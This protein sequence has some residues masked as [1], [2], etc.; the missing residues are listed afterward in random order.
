MPWPVGY[1]L[2]ALIEP[3]YFHAKRTRDDLLE[4][5]E[6]KVDGFDQRD[7]RVA[8]VR[9]I[10]L[11]L[12]YAAMNCA[13]LQDNVARD[14]WWERHPYMGAATPTSVTAAADNYNNELIASVV[15]LPFIHWEGNIRRLVRAI[16]KRACAGGTAALESVY[17][18]LLTRLDRE[19][20]GSSRE[21]TKGLLDLY[22]IIRNNVLHNPGSNVYV[23][24]DQE[25]TWR[26][27]TYE[28]CLGQEFEQL[29]DA[30]FVLG[31][32]RDLVDVTASIMRAPL[33]AGLPAIA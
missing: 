20:W 24:R 30:N 33:V 2:G 8:T 18:W 22:R 1:E 3:V 9:G 6:R 15:Y 12:H 29:E 16:D 25:A 5:Y 23:G 17:C 10:F 19:A 26:G 14:E 32:I 31:L 28:F 11:T 21:D 7:P 13:H 27:V 4:E